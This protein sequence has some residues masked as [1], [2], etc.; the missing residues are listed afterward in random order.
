M[1]NFKIQ[2]EFDPGE[3]KKYGVGKNFRNRESNIKNLVS[4]K[5]FKVRQVVQ[6]IWWYRK[7]PRMVKQYK[8]YTAGKNFLNRKGNKKIRCRKKFSVLENC[9]KIFILQ[10]IFNIGKLYKIFDP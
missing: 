1:S 9:I 2:T 4:E 7:F 5:T 10:K 6:K 8:K 3:N